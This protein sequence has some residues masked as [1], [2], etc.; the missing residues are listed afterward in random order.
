MRDWYV[1][2][3]M[4]NDHD[5]SLV[6]A[7]VYEKA[8][9]N[10]HPSFGPRERQT[11]KTPPFKCA[12]EGWGEFEMRIVLTPSGKGK[13]HSIP[14]DLNFAENDYEAN[15]KVVRARVRLDVTRLVLTPTADFPEPQ[16]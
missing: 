1:Q 13:D 4:V 10:L 16:G 3:Y 15:H 7:D 8:V 14:H 6:P 11:F 5:G 12:E 2:I 9:Y